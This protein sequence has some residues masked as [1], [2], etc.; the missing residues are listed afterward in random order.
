[1]IFIYFLAPYQ[2][3]VEKTSV[4]FWEAVEGC[5]QQGKVIAVPNSIDE[6]AILYKILKEHYGTD[7][8]WIGVAKHQ[9]VYYNST[10]GKCPIYCVWVT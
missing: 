8:W 7:Q 2:Y 3:S 4:N 6:N 5:N 1:M 10:G 9:N